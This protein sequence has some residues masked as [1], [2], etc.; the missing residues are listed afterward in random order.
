LDKLNST[1]KRLRRAM[2]QAIG[3]YQM[4]EDGDRIVVGLSGGKDSLTLLWLLNERLGRIPIDYALFPVYIDPGFKP[5]FADELS[6]YLKTDGHDLIVDH[7]DFGPVA[8]SAI[9]RENPCFLCS[10]R[11]RQRLFEIADELGCRKVALGHNQDDL[12]ETLFINICYAGEIATMMP[13]QSFFKG[14]MTIIRPLA[15]APEKDIQRFAEK[16]NFPAFINPCPSAGQSK[17]Q[18][19]KT[20]LNALYRQNRK[21]RGN[22]FRAMHHVSP[23]YLPRPSIPNGGKGTK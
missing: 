22:I 15:H 13:W 17:R 7:T 11:R 10:R 14:A 5:D 1:Y 9:N 18:E 4:I 12:I 2:G 16:S 20:L 3:Q 8:H 6:I 19:I 21:I 23:D